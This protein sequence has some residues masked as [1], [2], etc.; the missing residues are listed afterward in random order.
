MT[1]VNRREF[2]KSVPAASA[3]AYANARAQATQPSDRAGSIRVGTTPYRPVAEYAIQPTPSFDIEL[4]DSFW[5]PKVAANAEVT[6]PFEVAKLTERE[7]VLSGNVLEAA[8]V[9]L[10]TYPNPAIQARVDQAVQALASRAGAGNR[11]FEAAATLYRTTGRRGLLDVS[12][13]NAE[14]LYDDF[15]RN[16][17]PF[18]GG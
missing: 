15:V 4:K 9:S 2:L 7:R 11:D 16:D 3:L 14:A 13:K 1:H 10:R 5:K 12:I 8:I 18:S 6:I 17:P